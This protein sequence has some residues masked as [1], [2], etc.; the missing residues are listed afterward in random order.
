[1]P[2]KGKSSTPSNSIIDVLDNNW[3]RGWDTKIFN[4]PSTSSNGI[5][6]VL[7]NN[8]A[9]DTSMGHVTGM[10]KYVPSISSSSITGGHHCQNE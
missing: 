1:M 9:I 7:D 4:V 3:S 10:Q 5:I 6:D 2:A 8:F